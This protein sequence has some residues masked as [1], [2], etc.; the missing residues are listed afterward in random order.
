[1]ALG[2]AIISTGLH[3]ENKIAPA[4]NAAVGSELVAVYSRDR[5]RA[6]DF[7]QR[8]GASA[9]FD[10]LKDLLNDSRVDAV[11]IC[12]PNALHARQT[13]QAAQ[14]GKHVL[15]EK[16]MATTLEDAAMMVKACRGA[17]VK[18]GVGFNLRQHP[19][20]ILARDLIAQGALGRVNLAQ[21]QWGFGVR[22]QG[23]PSP[24][25]GLRQ[26]WDQPELIGDASTMM[27]TGVHVGDLLRFLLGQEVTQVATISDGQT[28]DHPLEQL[29]ALSLRF[30]GGTIGTLC[31]GRVLPDSRNDF[32]I[33]GSD[34][35]IS[36]RAT[37]W[38]VRQG[39]VEIVGETVN[40]TQ[41]TPGS[42]LGNFTAEIQDFQQAIEQDREPAATGIDGLRV[43]EVTLAM[44]ESARTGRTVTIQQ[45]EI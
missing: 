44:I 43:V 35:R 27:G 18:L 2:W 24:R 6:N 3:P 17:G 1:M 5:G 23:P 25:T 37:L 12:S 36:G 10:S 14:A 21:G 4:I 22:G 31:C 32:T 39:R 15:S 11:F 34:G 29:A 16:P 7:A 38:E 9:A 33:Y 20:H 45:T 42:Y 41:V 26:W 40:R 30:S 8:H 28:Q 19:G 13:V